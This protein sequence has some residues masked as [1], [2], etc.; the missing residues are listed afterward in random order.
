MSATD[1]SE[2][3][4]K[5]F[6]VVVADGE[7]GRLDRFLAGHLSHSRTR[8]QALIEEGTVQVQGQTSPVSKKQDVEPGQRIVV[9]VPPAR[10]VSL[11]AE[12]LPLN[13]VFQDEDV[14][15]VDKAAG[16]VVH[17]A[18]GHRSGTMVNALLHHVRDLSG[19]GG[20]LRPGIVHRLDQDTS[21]LLVVAKNDL[22]HRSLQDALRSRAMTRRYVAATW[23][24][25]KDES[26]VI[27]API[28]RHP[29]QRTQ[30]AVVADG[31][32]ARTHVTVRER[33]LAAELL[34][35]TLD[36]G[37][38]HQIRVH[39]LHTGHPVAGDPVYGVGWNRGMGGTQRRWAREFLALLS[40]QF[41]HASELAFPHPRTEVE[42]RFHSELPA[43]LAA[44]SAWAR[45]HATG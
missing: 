38:T 19:V 21:G 10:P 26:V 6:E 13:I 18:P 42:M 3:A 15:V 23:G 7:G 30:M 9:T 12:N 17:P 22:A 11:E 41:L 8:I 37:R 40:R 28:G 31:R 32:S 45:D 1:S 29:K 39:L 16:M 25:L 4:A 24:H 20:R 33:W 2:G 36:T 14:A 35:V 5:R 44:A 34:D 27:D 43:E